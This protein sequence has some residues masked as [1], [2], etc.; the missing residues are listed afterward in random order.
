M[1]SQ[2]LRMVSK[3]FKDTAL[4]GVT[5][6]TFLDHALQFRAQRFQPFHPLLNEFQL[7]A[8]DFIGFVTWPVR[9]VRQIKQLPDRVERK[10]QLSAVSN[11]CEAIE[12]SVT[13][14]PLPAFGPTRFRHQTNLLIIPDRLN[15]GAS[16]L[17]ECPN[18]EHVET[19][20][21][22]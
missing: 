3:H 9:R 7:A 8:R 10:S 14:A 19:P 17:R 4:R 13:I 5:A 18:C 22:L 12:F 2:T 15:L 16:S 6:A 20:L 1:L 21:I 11:E